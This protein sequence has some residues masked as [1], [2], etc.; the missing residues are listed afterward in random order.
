[1]AVALSALRS[2]LSEAL[3]P[4]ELDAVFESLGAQADLVVYDLDRKTPPRLAWRVDIAT[5]PEIAQPGIGTVNG[6]YFLYANGT[7]AGQVFVETSASDSAITT[8]T[9]RISI[10]TA[11]KKENI[12]GTPASPGSSNWDSS[13]AAAY[14]NLTKVYAYYQNILGRTS[15]DGNDARITATVLPNGYANA[16]WQRSNDLRNQQLAFGGGDLERALDVVGHEFTHAVINYVIGD[17]RSHSLG[18]ATP[19]RARSTRRS[20]TSWAT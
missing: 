16:F 2:K 7:D 15:Y 3:D 9:P 1:M 13:T 14:D 18:G 5:D 12:P 6:T 20:L 10:Y 4:A 8:S 11:A 19:S 17:G